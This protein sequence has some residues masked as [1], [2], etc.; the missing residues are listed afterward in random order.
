MYFEVTGMLTTESLTFVAIP[1]EHLPPDGRANG[2]LVALMGSADQAVTLGAL[3]FSCANGQ[4]ALAGWDDR[5]GAIR[6]LV[7]MDLG[8]RAGGIPPGGTF[9]GESR[10]HFE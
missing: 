6:A 2:R 8:R 4:F 5:S 3:Q 10:H 1:R 9:S 7:D